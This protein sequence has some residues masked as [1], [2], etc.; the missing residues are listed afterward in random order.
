MNQ[1]RPFGVETNEVGTVFPVVSALTVINTK[2]IGIGAVYT[3][4]QRHAY[5]GNSNPASGAD[6]EE[7]GA[8]TVMLATLQGGVALDIAMD[9]TAHE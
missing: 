4:A 8:L 7:V 6:G 2:Q 5:F 9:A 3:L 1:V